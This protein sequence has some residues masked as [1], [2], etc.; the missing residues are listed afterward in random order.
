MSSYFNETKQQ[1]NTTNNLLDKNGSI[2][3]A[4]LIWMYQNALSDSLF[5]SLARDSLG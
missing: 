4:A 2:K 5:Y 1:K 3:I